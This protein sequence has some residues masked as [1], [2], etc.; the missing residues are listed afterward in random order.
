[1]HVHQLRLTR[2][3]H[4]AA[5]GVHGQDAICPR[6]L[7]MRCLRDQLDDAW[8]HQNKRHARVI[9]I[10]HKEEIAGCAGQAADY[11]NVLSCPSQTQRGGQGVPTE[12]YRG[13]RLL[14]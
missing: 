4:M 14:Q 11:T 7:L 9:G 5:H 1:M 3:A 8:L 10:E 12:G 6:N 2:A 13:Q